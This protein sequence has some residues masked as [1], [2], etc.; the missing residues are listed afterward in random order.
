MNRGTAMDDRVSVDTEGVESPAN[1][2]RDLGDRLNSIGHSL[3]GRLDAI[4]PCWGDDSNGRR[5]EQ[6]YLPARNELLTG[7][8]SLG[9]VLG[10]VA[11]RLEAMA[12]DYER[13][14]GEAVKSARRIV[15]SDRGDEQGGGSATPS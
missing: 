12:H 14:E 2:L 1:G 9:D 13:T 8:T 7:T 5:F 11:D 10:T 3:Q 15:A 6:K 4:G